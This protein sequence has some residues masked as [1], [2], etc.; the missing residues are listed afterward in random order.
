MRPAAAAVVGLAAFWLPGT[1]LAADWYVD[2]SAA[3]GGNG[4]MATPFQTI[5]AALAGLSRGDTV[6]I[7]SGTYDETVDIEN[8]PGSSGARTT[9][10]ALPGATPVI[11]G[12]SGSAAAG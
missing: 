8:L 5:N 6:W 10:S 12:T 4:S 2:A 7:A 9:F 11:D 1:A 3:A